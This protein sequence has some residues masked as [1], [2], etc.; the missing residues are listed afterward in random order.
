MTLFVPCFKRSDP[1]HIANML[2]KEVVRLRGL[3]KS[4]DSNTYTM[5][6]GHYGKRWELTLTLIQPIILKQIDK[7]KSLIRFGT[8]F[9]EF[10]Q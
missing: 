6:V 4:I 5:I 10:S 7:L 2:F 1:N 9:K 8:I 3:P